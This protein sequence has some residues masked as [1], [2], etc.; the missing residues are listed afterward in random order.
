M[1][2]LLKAVVGIALVAA[3]GGINRSQASTVYTDANLKGCYGF[4]SNSVGQLAPLNSSIVGTICFDGK[5][6]IVPKDPLSGEAQ[7]GWTMN[8]GGII[9]PVMTVAG[10]YAVTNSPGQGMG[11]FSFTSGGCGSYVFSFNEVKAGV[12]QGFQFVIV[13][14]ENC[15]TAPVQGGWARLQP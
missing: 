8:V 7:T 10:T 14:G 13:D 4:L 15:G 9:M 3:L 2:S 11:T 5:G 6:H 1:K 12:A